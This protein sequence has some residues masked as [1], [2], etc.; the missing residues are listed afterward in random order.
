MVYSSLLLKLCKYSSMGLSFGAL[1]NTSILITLSMLEL[2]DFHA[3]WHLSQSRTKNGGKKWAR[4]IEINR[5][6]DIILIIFNYFPYP[7]NDN[8]KGSSRTMKRK[9]RI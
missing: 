7:D 8:I 1:T 9:M 3:F 2:S 4:L 5:I 6:L